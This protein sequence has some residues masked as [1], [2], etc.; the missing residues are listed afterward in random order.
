M[1]KLLLSLS[2][3]LLF[4]TA[5]Q[6]Q[7]NFM[8]PSSPGS[9]QITTSQ[10]LDATGTVYWICTGLTVTINSSTGATFVCEEGV[11][12]DINNS[13]G[14]EVYAKSGVVI[15]NNST[16]GIGVTANST[17]V[18]MNN[19]SSG[20]ITMT[21]T[22]SLVEYN[23]L[24]VGSSAGCAAPG[25]GIDQLEMLEID[26]FPNPV[27]QGDLVNLKNIGNDVESISVYSSAGQLVLSPQT[28]AK[29]L[30][31]ND[32]Q[33]GHYFLVVQGQ[34]SVSRTAFIVL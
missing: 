1:K 11:T 17:N 26:L 6:A 10:T 12:L 28:S 33:P 24:M 7:C 25:T 20:F 9:T 32:L 18:T 2:L 15:N 22:C 14:D 23:Y 30:A 29:S 31:T 3:T 16:A 4:G 21:A 19:N 27:A 5:L 8:I 34:N 13:D